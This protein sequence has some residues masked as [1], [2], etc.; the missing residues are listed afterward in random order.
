VTAAST[1]ARRL[2]ELGVLVTTLVW[3]ANFVVVKA[4]IGVLGPLVFTGARYAVASLTLLAVMRLQGRRIRPPGGQL[5]VLLGL[6][7]IGFGGYQLLWTTGL[8]QIS[9]GD[10]ALIVAA[11]PVLVALLAAA[12]G[13]DQVTAPKALG[14]MTAFAGVAVVIASGQGLSLG[15]SLV[16]D[17]LTLGAATLWAVYTVGGTRVLRTIDPLQATTWTV[18]GGALVLIPVGAI[19]ALL[20]PPPPLSPEVVVGIVYSGALAAAIANVFVF[21]AIRFIGPTRATTMQLLVP[22]GAVILGAVFLGEPLGP[23]QLV[24]GVVI[25]FGVWLTRRP[26]ILSPALSHRIARGRA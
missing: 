15:A 9:A 1:T 19:D 25:V 17:A 21:N 8:T 20:R 24:G 14:A 10:S 11:S 4:A 5:A 18:I 22:A 3:S 12:V 6:G 2:A 16:G 13:L 26:R 23:G 7:V